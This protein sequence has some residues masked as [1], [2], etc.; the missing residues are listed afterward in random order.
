MALLI[1]LRTKR[2]QALFPALLPF[3]VLQF[4]N[5][6]VAW[7]FSVEIP[8]HDVVYKL[9]YGDI[10]QAITMVGGRDLFAAVHGI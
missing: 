10:L 3:D 9:G 6:L 4:M 2:E 1:A 8:R 5:M 7:R